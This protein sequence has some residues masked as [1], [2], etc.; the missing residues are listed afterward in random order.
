MYG[1]QAKSRWPVCS[2]GRSLAG[3]EG[4]AGTFRRH[5][6]CRRML[7]IS[8]SRLQ[9]IESLH[10]GGPDILPWANEKAIGCRRTDCWFS[11]PSDYRRDSPLQYIGNAHART[12]QLPACPQQFVA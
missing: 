2:T 7:K 12:A 1:S 10:P 8:P 6:A 9:H 11:R 5:Q 4:K 3:P